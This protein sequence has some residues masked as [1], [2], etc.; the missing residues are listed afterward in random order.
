MKKSFGRFLTESSIPQLVLT[1]FMYVV[2]V[3][4]FAV[5]TFP[6]VFLATRYLDWI[7][8]HPVRIAL[9]I[10]LGFYLFVMTGMVYLSLS[11]RVITLGMKEGTYPVSS[12]T[13]LRWLFQSGF[14]GMAVIFILPFLRLTIFTNWFYRLVGTRIGKNARLATYT[15]P[16]AY[17]LTVGDGVVV[18]AR[19]EISCHIFEG[20]KLVLGRVS[21]G[22]GSLVGAHC[23]I[24]P[25]VEI[26]KKCAIGQYSQL[27]RGMKVPDN[28]KMGSLAALP[29]RKIMAMEKSE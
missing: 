4:N 13:F 24:S 6:T 3:F 27:R 19:A 12:F 20:A 22:D 14:Y 2:Y 17:L 1:L 10:G 21:I 5:M 29:L 28:S 18:G 7:V 25:G 16:D 9:A 15:L 8:V 23:H 26:G 11:I